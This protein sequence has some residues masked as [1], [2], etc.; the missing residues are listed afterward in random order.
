VILSPARLVLVRHGQSTYNASGHL[1][2][3]TDTALSDAGRAEAT[4][5]RP[6]LAHFEQVVTR[7]REGL[8]RMSF[9]INHAADLETE[10]GFEEPDVAVLEELGRFLGHAGLKTLVTD[11]ALGEVGAEGFYRALRFVEH[12]PHR[13]TETGPFAMVTEDRYGS[14]KTI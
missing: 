12:S 10:I 4:A 13:R 3:Q 11:Q 9:A 5:L 7:H 2:G 14:Q 8:R 1:Q 6:F